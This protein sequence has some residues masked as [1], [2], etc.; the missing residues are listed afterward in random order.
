MKKIY[1]FSE[2]DNL[3]SYRQ[4]EKIEAES[5]TVAKKIASRRQAFQGTSLKIGWGIDSQ[6]FIDEVLAVKEPGKNKKWKNL[7]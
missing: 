2:V 4:A 1:Y 5:L 6:G 3:N 7:F